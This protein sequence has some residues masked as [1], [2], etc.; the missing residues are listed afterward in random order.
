[1]RITK[2]RDERRQE[3]L[4]AAERLFLT[5]G[6]TETGV[7]DIV[8]E[9]GVAQGTF[10]Y[11]FKT[12]EDVLTA[13]VHKTAD[14][15]E[16]RLKRIAGNTE[17]S[18]VDRLHRLLDT[19]FLFMDTNKHLIALVHMD[20]NA[21]LHHRLMGTMS[22]IIRKYLL[23]FAD[24]GIKN[25]SFRTP[26]RDE[27]IDFFLGG[28]TSRLHRADLADDIA[29]AEQF[30]AAVRMAASRLFQYPDPHEEIAE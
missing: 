28:L 9:T 3:L 17:L 10:Y 20:S 1:M 22:R 2:N 30:R 27:T 21:L 26:Y 8:R 14:E 16:S 23:L 19:L 29:K 7:S 25:G 4:E 6:Y 5:N 11:H 12:K 18:P 15:L 13:I 24:E